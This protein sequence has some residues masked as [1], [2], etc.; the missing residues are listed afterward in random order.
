MGTEDLGRVGPII[1]EIV[2]HITV[3][4]DRLQ[5]LHDR[6]LCCPGIRFAGID[7]MVGVR[8][9]LHEQRLQDFELMWELRIFSG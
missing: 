3:W 5:L 8:R 4:T 9:A 2:W 7:R 1:A 6:D